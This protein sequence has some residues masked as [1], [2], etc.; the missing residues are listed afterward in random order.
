MVTVTVT[1]TVTVSVTV[2]LR[3]RIVA[4]IRLGGDTLRVRVRVGNEVSVRVGYRLLNG[5][6]EHR[7]LGRHDTK[8]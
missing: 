3:V 7:I 8:I 6:W 1:V 5:T 4:L 2:W